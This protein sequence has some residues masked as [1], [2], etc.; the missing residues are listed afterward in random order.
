MRGPSG[1][2]LHVHACEHAFLRTCPCVCVR[3]YACTGMHMCAC[4]NMRVHVYAHSYARV[5]GTCA[6]EGRHLLTLLLLPK[7]PPAADA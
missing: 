4:M 2:T 5:R 1:S 6:C 3:V 7:Y